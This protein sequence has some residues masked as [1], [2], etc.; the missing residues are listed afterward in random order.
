MVI[1]SASSRAI[2]DADNETPG[3]EVLYYAALAYQRQGDQAGALRNLDVLLLNYP[4]S[5]LL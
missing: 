4:D 5:N 1:S 3:A 2:T